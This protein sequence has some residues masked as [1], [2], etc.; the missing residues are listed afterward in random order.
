M[1][2]CPRQ[3]G[4]MVQFIAVGQ[5]RIEL[6]KTGRPVQYNHHSASEKPII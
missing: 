2:E 3:V 5:R 4:G 6:A 1:K